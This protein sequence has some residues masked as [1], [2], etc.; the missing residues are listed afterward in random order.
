MVWIYI[1]TVI[2][3]MYYM[4]CVQL[5]STVYNQ[6]TKTRL[7]KNF[8]TI[9]SYCQFNLLES[10]FKVQLYLYIYNLKDSIW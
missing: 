7:F 9:S 6:S 5:L 3:I 1:T 4:L 10:L 2:K 8:T